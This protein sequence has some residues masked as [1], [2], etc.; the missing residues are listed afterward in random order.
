MNK[1]SNGEKNLLECK[2][3]K[4][5]FFGFIYFVLVKIYE[6]KMIKKKKISF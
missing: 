6:Y 4:N 3:K 2:L 1:S 5:Q